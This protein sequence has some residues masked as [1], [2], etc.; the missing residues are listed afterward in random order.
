MAF[1]F[2]SSWVTL[3][4]YAFEGFCAFHLN[5]QNY[6]HKDSLNN[7]IFFCSKN[8]RLFRN[9]AD[10]RKLRRQYKEYPH[11]SHSV[12]PVMALVWSLQVSSLKEA[13]GAVLV[14]C[15]ELSS[16]PHCDS[17]VSPPTV[18]F[19]LRIHTV[20]CRHTSVSSDILLVPQTLRLIHT[21]Q[22][23][24]RMFQKLSIFL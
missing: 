13:R 19:R 14:H 11:L 18:P 5:C 10:Y 4:I 24:C 12:L 21:E 16:Q 20:L 2:F 7:F 23:C 9:F 6:R 1:T 3:Q 17:S 22:L 15:S 8:K